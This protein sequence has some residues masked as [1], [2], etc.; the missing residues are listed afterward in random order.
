[1]EKFLK[2]INDDLN[3]RDNRIAELEAENKRLKK[4]I[5]FKNE[6]LQAIYDKHEVL[7]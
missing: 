1:M 4:E 2:K 5:A 7:G 3:I 6:K